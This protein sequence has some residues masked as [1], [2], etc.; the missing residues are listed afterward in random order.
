MPSW[1]DEWGIS[2]VPSPVKKERKKTK[3]TSIS[4]NKKRTK[5]ASRG[6]H[7]HRTGT[8][9]SGRMPLVGQPL[10]LGLGDIILYIELP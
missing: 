4:G 3:G 6:E 9:P 1:A 5:R 7:E 8:E 10:R 2:T